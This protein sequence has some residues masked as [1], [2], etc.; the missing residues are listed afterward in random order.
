[1]A[2]PRRSTPVALTPEEEEREAKRK[3]KI[4]ENKKKAGEIRSAAGRAETIRE[5]RSADNARS[6]R[7]PL[8]PSMTLEEILRMKTCTEG[9]SGSA[10]NGAGFICPVTDR[11]RRRLGH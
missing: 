7:C 10:H 8:T 5:I 2:K 6:C 3:L 4:A 1:M 11:L 9:G